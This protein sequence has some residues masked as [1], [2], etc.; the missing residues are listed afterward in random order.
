MLFFRHREWAAN[1]PRTDSV[2]PIVYIA[3][4]DREY[5]RRFLFG[6]SSRMRGWE[7]RPFEIC[8]PTR[9]LSEKTL[10]E[11]VVILAIVTSRRLARQ[12]LPYREKVLN[13]SSSSFGEAFAT[14]ANDGLKHGAAAAAHLIEQG[15]RHLAIFD[16]RVD[17]PHRA[18]FLR[19]AARQRIP[20]V[21]LAKPE[22]ARQWMRATPAPSGLFT[23][24]NW[25][26]ISLL[27]L[28]LIEGI[29][30]P[31]QLLV[32]GGEGDTLAAELGQKGLTYIAPPY[33]AI[34]EKACA[35]ILD[36]LQN[37]RPL[38]S[39]ATLLAPLPV[40][41]SHSTDYVETSD[42]AVRRAI[43]FIRDQVDQPLNVEAVARHTGLPRRALERRFQKFHSRSI[44]EE[45]LR[46]R[47]ARARLLLTTTDWTSG[48]IAY[49]CGYGSQAHFG[50]VFLSSEG[51]TPLQYRRFKGQ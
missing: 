9:P 31:G 4:M 25:F 34:C 47:L 40:V 42:P 17:Y 10:A 29:D 43:N 18:G 7:R 36:F 24:D 51:C 45:I 6:I 41:M 33:R 23:L 46:S 2:R 30:V 22:T 21:H 26:A 3:E 20:A 50:K 49:E 15:A 39:T 11:A 8:D 28:A 5:S 37:G 35:W 27:N 19:E 14:V 1:T 13:L 48:R 44:L 38:C 32:L 16:V 12:L